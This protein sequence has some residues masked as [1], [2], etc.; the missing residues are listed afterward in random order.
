MQVSP[1]I[2]VIDTC[3][4]ETFEKEEIRAFQR[5]KRDTKFKHEVHPKDDIIKALSQEP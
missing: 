4:L 3:G 2:S 1:I 5:A